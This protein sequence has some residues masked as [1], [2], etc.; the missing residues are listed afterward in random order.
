MCL[1]VFAWQMLPDTP[2]FAAA[3]RDEFYDRPAAPANW[4]EDHPHVFAGRDLQAGGTWM[5]VSHSGQCASR[6]AALTNVR[7]PSEFRPDAPSRGHLVSNYL[8]SDMSPQQYIEEIGKS[9]VEFNGFNLLVGDRDTLI[10]YSNRGHGKQRNGLPLRP[11]IYGLSN[12]LLNDPWHKVVKTRAQFG[13]LLFQNAPDDAYFDMLADT[14][15]APDFRLPETGVDL[16]TERMLSAV[17]IESPQYGTRA[18]TLV[19]LH[20]QAPAMLNEQLLR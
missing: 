20:A 14:T 11:G 4:W 1:I 3:N 13:S 17:C 9:A 10:W 16:E 15:R 7:A 5:G 8:T 18:S 2:L 12:A 6:F 19:R